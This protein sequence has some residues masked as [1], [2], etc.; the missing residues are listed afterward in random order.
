[1]LINSLE[2]TVHNYED[3][4]VPVGRGNQQRVE[5]ACGR[6]MRRL[7]PGARHAVM[8]DLASWTM[9]CHQKRGALCFEDPLRVEEWGRSRNPMGPI[10]TGRTE[11][12]AS[13][14]GNLGSK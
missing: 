13:R 12:Q 4:G 11:C 6:L 2:K 3:D 1:M 5:K 7:S 9:E 10:K 8:K 14:S